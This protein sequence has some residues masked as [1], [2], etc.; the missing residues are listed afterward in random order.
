MS[1]F[2]KVEEDA[3]GNSMM[4]NSQ[5]GRLRRWEQA[6]D[7][8]PAGVSDTDLDELRKTPGMVNH[9]L[10]FGT[11]DGPGIRFVLF[12][13]GCPLRCLYCHNPDMVTGAAKEVWT[14]EKALSTIMRYRG[15]IQSGGVTFS[16]GEPLAQHKFVRALALLAH[17]AGLH[18]A[19]DTSGCMDVDEVKDAIDAADMLL[20][21][22]KAFNPEVAVKLTGQDNKNAFATLD[23]CEE[24]GKRV[25]IRHVLVKGYTL[26]AGQL[27]GLA[28]RL[29]RY[30][31]ID[32]I[33]LLPFHKL[34]EEK[35]RRI[36][37]QYSLA[38]V[39]ATSPGEVEWAK[40]F[41]TNEGLRVQ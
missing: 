10:T 24:K 30:E 17:N 34:G 14:A 12:L 23:Y 9:Y 21:D 3:T 27:A 11:V 4:I 1:P 39:P 7:V 40:S 6:R 19:I 8:V 38:D 25:W 28:Q 16:G 36:G 26:D 13:Q 31:C 41:F 32:L 5:S 22:I 18:T 35:W 20:L 15:F 29:R 2:K 37:R 33:E